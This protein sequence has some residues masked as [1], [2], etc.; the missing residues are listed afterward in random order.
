MLEGN[1]RFLT[2]T[3]KCSQSCYG[4]PFAASNAMGNRKKSGNLDLSIETI[5]AYRSMFPF[6]HLL[7][8]GGEPFEHKKISELIVSLLSMKRMQGLVR[9]ATGGHIDLKP[10]YVLL[11]KGKEQLSGISMGT[12][13]WFQEHE[14][15]SEY[16]NNWLSNLELLLKSPTDVSLTFWLNK[17]TLTKL[18][19][20]LSKFEANALSFIY[21]RFSQE[22]NQEE[23]KYA[24]TLLNE[25]FPYL[26]V[27]RIY[28]DSV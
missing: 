16:T 9:F 4:C 3:E 15:N 24:L 10:Y 7:I 17:R 22:L 21:L 23:L 25:K 28:A 19:S 6:Q 18:E 20:V 1:T 14:V 26:G 12:D 8:S 2:I 5:L 11:M 27:D 13:L